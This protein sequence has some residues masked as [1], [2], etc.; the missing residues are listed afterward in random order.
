MSLTQQ[1]HLLK[2]ICHLVDA[3]CD[4]HSPPIHAPNTAA[5]LQHA[6][7]SVAKSLLD[8]RIKGRVFSFEALHLLLDASMSTLLLLQRC[9]FAG[10]GFAEAA[11][12][13]I[14]I[15]MAPILY[16]KIDAAAAMLNA[17]VPSF[18]PNGS[19]SDF[20]VQVSAITRQAPA[21]SEAAADAGSSDRSQRFAELLMRLHNDPY[22]PIVPG[23]LL[24]LRM[25][26]SSRTS[27][28]FFCYCCSH[29][30]CD[31]WQHF[32][33]SYLLSDSQ[34]NWRSDWSCHC[35]ARKAL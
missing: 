22:I 34:L 35:R 6:L 24:N 5:A 10:Q 3:C 1:F 25:V 4:N 8:Q 13:H 12:A 7:K 14:F 30:T 9:C 33:T 18:D 2:R 32:T 31:T 29:D 20:A 11:T 16:S 26:S 21:S 19:L 15:R 23:E 28:I 27:H 17:A